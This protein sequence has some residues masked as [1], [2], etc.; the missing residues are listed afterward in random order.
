[1]TRLVLGLTVAA[2]AGAAWLA[3]ALLAQDSAAA[4]EARKDRRVIAQSRSNDF[5]VKLVA[6][7]DRLAGEPDTATVEIRAFR[8][9]DGRWDRLGEPHRVGL[10][11]G[12]FWHVVTRPYGVHLLRVARPGGECADRVAVRLLVSPS[13]GPS[14]KYRF[15]TCDGRFHPVDV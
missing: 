15:A 7:R 12:W 1:M 13:I 10:R 9:D 11:S 8:R 14:A 6:T 3:T 4:G 5:A 2:L